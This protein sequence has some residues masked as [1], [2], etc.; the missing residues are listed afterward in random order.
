MRKQS[1]TQE[2]VALAVECFME[3]Q[4]LAETIAVHMNQ[5]ADGSM[6]LDHWLATGGAIR[7]ARAIIAETTTKNPGA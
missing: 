4:K 3:E 2:T 7:L 5:V 1:E 6:T